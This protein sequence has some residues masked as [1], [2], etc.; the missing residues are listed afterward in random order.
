MLNV[1]SSL[2]KI[3]KVLFQKPQYSMGLFALNH[4]LIDLIYTQKG[5]KEKHYLGQR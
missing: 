3:K 5:T 4:R 1:K 2:K